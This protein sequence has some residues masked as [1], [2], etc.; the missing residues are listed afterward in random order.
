[1]AAARAMRSLF[2]S[3]QLRLMVSLPNSWPMNAA[4]GEKIDLSTP[5]RAIASRCTCRVALS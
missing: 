2:T 1:M 5:R 3:V 4:R